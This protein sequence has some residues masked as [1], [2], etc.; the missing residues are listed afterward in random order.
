MTLPRRTP[1]AGGHISPP[2]AGGSGRRWA[3]GV[4][5]AVAVAGTAV[6]VA[7]GPGAEPVAPT[8]A[9]V[10]EVTGPGGKSSEIRFT[11]DGANTTERVE[12]V[13]LPWRRELVVPAGP[14]LG[15][16]QVMATNGQGE[17]ITCTITVNGRVVASRTARGEFTTVSC[18][19]MMTPDAARG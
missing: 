11:T 16:A 18:S 4:A 17:S 6:W 3:V 8:H 13:D 15:I 9:V 12:A 2:A 7:A 1:T 10:Y 5:A 19:N 14:G